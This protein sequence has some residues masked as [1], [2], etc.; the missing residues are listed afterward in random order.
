M[1]RLLLFSCLLLNICASWAQ[2]ISKVSLPEKITV[3]LGQTIDLTQYVT[4]EPAGATLPSDAVWEY[5]KFTEWIQVK[6]N[7]LTGLALGYDI[8]LRLAIPYATHEVSAFTY[9][10]VIEAQ[11]KAINIKSD[12]QSITVNVGETEKLTKFLAEAYEIVPAGAVADIDWAIADNSIIKFIDYWDDRQNYIEEYQPIKAGVTTLTPQ[13]L[14]AADKGVKLSSS[15]AV[16]VTV[17]QPVKGL[18]ISSSLNQHECNVGDDLTS[19]LNSLVM[20]SPDDASDKSFTWSVTS[21]DA[22]SI[23]NGKISAVKAGR[24]VLTVTS[25]NNPKA[26]AQLTV[27]VY[28]PAT[29]I[30]FANSSLNVVYINKPVDISELL[31]RNISFLPSGYE[32]LE[33]LSVT[34]NN[35]VV[36]VGNVSYANGSVQLTAT[37]QSV[38]QAT[39]TVSITYHDYLKDYTVPGTA[40]HTNTV[41]KTFTVNVTQGAIPVESLSINSSQNLHEC[42]VGDDLTSYL[43]GLVTV[44]PENAADKSFTWSVASGDAVSVSNGRIYAAMA[45]RAELTVT[46]NNN[47]KATAQLMVLVHN[48][49]TD[50]QFANSSVSV[51]YVNK[52]VDISELLMRNISF[53]PSG[54]ESLEGLSVTSNNNVVSV[55]NVSYANGSVQLT[56]TAQSVG[57]ATITVSITYRDY[58]SDY[59]MPGTAGHTNTVT[60]TFTV[61]VTQGTIPV[62]SLSIN[63]SLNLHE[64]NVGDDLTAYLNG[65]VTVSPEN[66]DDKSFTWSVIS[67]DAVSVRNGKISAI[68]AGR[69][70]LTVTSNN[71]PKATAQLMV[72]VHNPATDIRFANSS[73]N[74]VYVNKPVDISDLLMRNISFLPSGYESVEGLSVTS[75]NNTVSVGNVS[76]A[77]GGV[78]L[79]ATAQS[80]GQ[81]IITVSITYRDYLK[82]YTVPGTAGHRNT[83]TKSFAVNVT[84]GTIP[85]ESLSINSSLNLHECNVGDELTAYLNGLVTVSPENAD[86]KSFT[87]SVTSGDAVS[88]SNGKISA[89]KAGRAELTVTS[90]N[91]PK[92]TA[93]LMVW[94]H[95]PAKDIQ[96]IENTINAEYDGTIS[97]ISQLLKDNIKFL[98]S[99]YETVEG[100]T[101]SSDRPNDVVAIDDVSY[102]QSGK[103]LVL[104]ARVL[105]AGKAII[106]V[107]IDYRDYLSDY[108]NPG[109]V[110]HRVKA[111]KTFTI[112]VKEVIPSVSSIIY[113]DELTL[114]RY[115]DVAL[116]LTILPEKARLDPALLEIR[117]SGSKNTDWGPAAVA[118][119]SPA[120]VLSWN[121]R[122]RYA[123]SYTYQVFYNGQ[124]QQTKSGARQGT[125]HT[126]VEYPLAQG[127]DWISLYATGPTKALALKTSSG[128]IAPMQV[129]DDNYVQEIRS[130]HDLL[131]KDPVSGFFG[132][133]EKLSPADGMYKVNSHYDMAKSDQMIL[134]AGYDGLV[135]ASELQ[136]PQTHKGYTWVTY[137][138][139][140]NHSINALG[141]YLRQ[142]ATEGDMIIGRDMFVIFDGKEWL[143]GNGCIFEAGKGYIYYTE[144]AEPKT[145]NWGPVTLAPEEEDNTSAAQARRASTE[146]SP[147]IYNPYAYPDCMAVLAQ[148]EEV[149]DPENY[150]VGVFVGEECRGQGTVNAEGLVC[151]AVSGQAGEDVTFRL[152][153]QP[154]ESYQ[155]LDGQFSFTSRIGSLSNPLRLHAGPAAICTIGENH[156]S[157]SISDDVLMVNGAEGSV[158]L[159]VTD[160]QGRYVA[161][162]RGKICSLSQL[163]AGVYI[164]CATDAKG[165]ITK[166]FKK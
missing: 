95:N 147:W 102:D 48:P 82:D 40:G 163:P 101:I 56:A 65:L 114:S 75:I 7:K 42:N 157:L 156:L 120:S 22:V 107:G 155:T 158:S 9:V 60:K 71:N 140:F 127:W 165:Q 111:Q 10:D 32:S 142:S 103:G 41:T 118:T 88:V 25:N 116:Q 67:G 115:H 49:A 164:V 91:N 5:T 108:T 152:Y 160:L 57:Q 38:G 133:I 78:Q 26:T 86:D 90:N 14:N 148:I 37:A 104:R 100:L 137:P 15:Q 129:D 166:K 105:G 39:I 80:V 47:P 76:Y 128:W 61:N 161:N 139:E 99:G 54:Y 98:P 89:I 83:V 29:D 145:I 4:I 94:V 31:M 64:C 21:G 121:I 110:E 18:W 66:A 126:P 81:T 63:S 45:G 138:H 124:L 153:H 123:G 87:W 70:E 53:L 44:S 43:N 69:A 68:K 130:Q 159:T 35:N 141:S 146:T 50:I 1:R 58:L 85:V 106:T 117:F 143:G 134:N 92:A 51:V 135:C 36:S 96:F 27:Q 46:S 2:S 119:P 28:N 93:Q 144:S 8:V 3:E 162:H 6:D 84:Q 52:P 34:S 20:I 149:A 19:Y 112:V 17:V 23:S 12:H 24:A 72:L 55:G 74:V 136:L 109:T 79:T 73:L 132:D 77:N 122:G 33:G 13:I 150:S 11:P 131:Y 154:T 113:P 125:I 62:E 97:D 16:T 30:Q 151:A 59:T